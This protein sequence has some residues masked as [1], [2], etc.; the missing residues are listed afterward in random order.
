MKKKVVKK[1]ITKKTVSASSLQSLRL[2]AEQLGEIIPATSM[3]K[4]GF[5]FTTLAKKYNLKKYWEN[6]GQKKESIASFL[7]LV[8][9]K[10]PRVLK[11]LIRENLSRA[12]E[13]RHKNGNPILRQEA[14][15]LST[16][17]SKLN[18][19]LKKEIGELDLPTTR[20]SIVPPRIEM[21]KALDVLSLHPMLLP[22]CKKLF[23]DG[24]LNESVRK[25]L[26]KY[27]VYVRDSSGLTLIGTNLMEQAFSE[28]GPKISI[29]NDTDARRKEGLQTGFKDISRGA[30]EYWR[31]YSSHGDEEQMPAQDAIS[32]LGVVSHL[33]YVVQKSKETTV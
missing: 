1:P 18:I 25:A 11:K 8:Y 13:R 9:K 22:D 7:I 4:T 30:M 10:H 27:E 3:N 12:I 21:Q 15:T 17:L 19:D 28:K 5:C 32:I 33:L 31:N 24:H 14:D 16:T 20:P 29:S 26:E 23:D 6:K 2:L